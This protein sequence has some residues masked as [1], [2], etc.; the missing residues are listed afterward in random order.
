MALDYYKVLGV[1]RNA[2][3]KAI[4]SAYRKL[5][6]RYHPDVNPGDK[7]AEAK[8]KEVSE[9][10][11]VIGDPEKRGLYDKYGHQ[12]EAVSRGGGAVP[13]MDFGNFSGGF[14]SFFEQ[15]LGGQHG[16]AQAGARPKGAPPRDL[17]REVSISLEE[18]ATGTKRTLSYTTQDACKTCDGTAFV[19]TRSARTCQACG[20]SG[21]SAGFFGMPQACQ[22]CAGT[23]QSTLESCPTCGGNGVMT[24]QRK[25]EVK[26]PKG[27]ADGQKLR[28]PGGGA[29]GSNG[30]NGDLYVII[31]EEKH[32][33]FTRRGADLEIEIDVPFTMAALGGQLRVETL[34]GGVMMKIPEG[35]QSGQ[36]F[37]LSGQ[38]LMPIRGE[39]GSLFVK[40]K[41]Q[42]PRKLTARQRE[43]LEEFE[44]IEV[45]V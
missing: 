31:R 32:P 7:E 34:D 10:Y 20:G 15:F 21:Q 33:H 26:I 42:M 30:R 43:L 35:T 25:V 12:W 19:R 11:E 36:K 27:I 45:T 6:R 4:K 40:I 13:D 38:G 22:A 1:D 23:G 18:V 5:A 37:R 3:E 14:G 41:I 24:A 39:Q 2:D 16:A 29:R 9:A 8:F 44:R 17:E 28:V